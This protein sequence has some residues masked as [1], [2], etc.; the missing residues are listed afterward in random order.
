MVYGKRDN[1]LKKFLCD[2]TWGQFH[3][4]NGTKDAIQFHQQICAQL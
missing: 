1:G 2:D 3:Q 4:V